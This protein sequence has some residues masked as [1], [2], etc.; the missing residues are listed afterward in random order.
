MNKVILLGNITADPE[1]TYTQNNIPVVSISLA[2]NKSYTDKKG[3]TIDAVDFHNLVAWNKMAEFFANYIT[4]WS[5]ILVEWKLQTRDWEWD[6]WKKRYKTEIL[7]QS[8]EFAGGKKI[9]SRN[10]D[11]FVTSDDKHWVTR[12]DYE[13][14]VEDIQF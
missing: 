3:T 5:K 14:P 4:K 7:V 6:D 8:V 10:Q 2:T 9:C 13:I 1:L 12:W 11:E